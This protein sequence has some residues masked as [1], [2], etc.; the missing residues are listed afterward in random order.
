[1]SPETAIR[2]C[3]ESM[4]HIAAQEELRIQHAKDIRANGRKNSREA[5]AHISEIVGLPPWETEEE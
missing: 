5:L 1:M 2:W 3:L 4:E